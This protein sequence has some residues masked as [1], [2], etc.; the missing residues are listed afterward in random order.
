MVCGYVIFHTDAGTLNVHKFIEEK[1]FIEC[2]TRAVYKLTSRLGFRSRK[3]SKTRDGYSLT[4]EISAKDYQSFVKRL[5]CTLFSKIMIRKKV[6]PSIS[7]T[8]ATKRMRGK[9]WDLREGK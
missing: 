3:L 4:Y 2:G 5:L 7:H 6:C 9:V 1:L 8:Q